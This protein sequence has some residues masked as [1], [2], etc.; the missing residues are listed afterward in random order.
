MKTTKP[1][2]K[3]PLKKA[4]YGTSIKRRTLKKAQ[5]GDSMPTLSSIFDPVTKEEKK[6]LRKERQQDRKEYLKDPNISFK[7]KVD[8]YRN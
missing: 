1:A 6:E 5:D 8:R 4:M 3:K 2:V 7:D